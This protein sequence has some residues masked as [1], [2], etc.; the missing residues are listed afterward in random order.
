MVPGLR[1]PSF[2]ERIILK[3]LLEH[4]HPVQAHE[5]MR[6]RGI[7]PTYDQGLELHDFTTDWA[8]DVASM[9][10]EALGGGAGA[11]V[12]GSLGTGFGGPF[13][14]AVGTLGGLATG[15][16]VGAGAGRLAKNILAK[17]LVDPSAELSSG[18]ASDAAVTGTLGGLLGGGAGEV[19]TGILKRAAQS[20]QKNLPA[21]VP[22]WLRKGVNRVARSFDEVQLDPPA[23]K[24]LYTEP[25]K[26]LLERGTREK[27]T[28]PG[29]LPSAGQKMIDWGSG[30]LTDLPTDVAPKMRREVTKEHV[31]FLKGNKA[32]GEMGGVSERKA[33]QYISELGERAARSYRATKREIERMLKDKSIA[34]PDITP[35]FKP[36]LKP[37]KV[38]KD[39]VIEL[40]PEERQLILLSNFF[41][42]K[43]TRWIMEVLGPKNFKNY[44]GFIRR[45]NSLKNGSLTGQDALK[46]TENIKVLERT[47]RTPGSNKRLGQ[48]FEGPTLTALTDLKDD[49]F[50]HMAAASENAP[51]FRT[52]WEDNIGAHTD[53]KL[54]KDKYGK[55]FGVSQPRTPGGPP[56]ANEGALRDFVGEAT[57][58][59]QRKSKRP[60]TFQDVYRR[61]MHR[62]GRAAN[63]KKR[64]GHVDDLKS[65][66]DNLAALNLYDRG[67]PGD[68]SALYATTPG[69]I[70]TSAQRFAHPVS[71]FVEGALHGPRRVIPEGLYKQRKEGLLTHLP[72]EALEASRKTIP[73]TLRESLAGPTRRAPPRKKSDQ[74]EMSLE[75]FKR[76]AKSLSKEE[77]LE[78]IKA[79]EKK[80][81]S[82]EN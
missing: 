14:G 38:S 59:A 51:R 60:S 58:R 19:S 69:T 53:F 75:E 74:K 55:G 66:D 34:K 2:V 28:H 41:P 5:F 33:R 29:L 12:G 61:Q 39:G 50:R 6:K 36:R 47:L 45:L 35:K 63:W 9:P 30:L 56:L 76:E 79:I 27:T 82:L 71:D 80:E 70:R 25:G 23:V 73:P 15:M 46:L 21:N 13:G 77:I 44:S 57:L 8:G 3:S 49:L 37:R 40:T 20:L 32:L 48:E 81:K 42:E 65:Y 54:L 11:I 26:R 78:L 1:K 52:V 7:D 17:G 62:E 31:A 43:E 16:G 22:Q 4:Y 67:W 72:Y 10:L 68:S 18:V 64:A 24:R